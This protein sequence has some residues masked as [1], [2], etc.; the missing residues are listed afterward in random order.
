MAEKTSQGLAFDLRNAIFAKVK[1]L[2]FSYYDRNQTG[3]LMI[4]ATDDVERVR[5]FIAQGLVMAAQAFLQ[6]LTR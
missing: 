5:M 1:R 6:R 4:R 2:S 3:Q